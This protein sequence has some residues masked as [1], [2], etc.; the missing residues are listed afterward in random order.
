MNKKILNRFKTPNYSNKVATNTNP[1]KDP[2]E[3]AAAL[4]SLAGVDS[5]GPEG[6]FAA[7]APPGVTDVG[8]AGGEATVEVGE[9]TGGEVGA[10]VGVTD[11]GG[12]LARDGVGAAVLG[13]CDIGGVAGRG[14]LVGD[15]P[16]A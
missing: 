13:G 1:V 16:G 2:A 8:G 7:G 9:P 5:V 4:L 10:A 15:G 11:G 14:D 12:V 3:S 6:A